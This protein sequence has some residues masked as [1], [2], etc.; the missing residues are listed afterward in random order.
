MATQG[1]EYI[2]TTESLSAFFSKYHPG[3]GSKLYIWGSSL[4]KDSTCFMFSRFQRFMSCQ[5]ETPLFLSPQSTL[6]P[7][8]RSIY[9]L[10][11]LVK[12]R[13]YFLFAFFSFSLPSPHLE[14][15]ANITIDAGCQFSVPASRCLFWGR[16]GICQK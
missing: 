4:F 9:F 10:K 6:N 7:I 14:T 2:W 15:A 12:N 11:A 1:S 8:F 16:V 5:T 13:F 3:H